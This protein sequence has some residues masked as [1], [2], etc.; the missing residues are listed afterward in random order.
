M[1]GVPTT[2][3]L[4]N[5]QQ[6]IAGLANVQFGGR[7]AWPDDLASLYGGVDLVWA[8]DFHDAGANSRW[9]LPNRLYEGGYYAAPPVAPA[10]SETARWMKEHLWGTIIPDGWD[11]RLYTAMSY[12]FVPNHPDLVGFTYTPTTP[13]LLDIMAIQAIYGANTSYNAGSTC[14][15]SESS[16]TRLKPQSHAWLPFDAL[17]ESVVEN[18]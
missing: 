6:D 10:D 13:M 4:P 16:G 14:G 2:T 9:L 15:V 3:D 5:F 12:S 18:A 8:G 1:R 11:G 17:V 7:Y